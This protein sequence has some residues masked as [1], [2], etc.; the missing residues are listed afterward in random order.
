VGP[1][2][3][4][5]PPAAERREV[6]F[7]DG[8]GYCF[9]VFLAMRLALSVLSMSAT[10]VVHAPGLETDTIPPLSPGWHNIVEGTDRWDAKRFVEIAEFGYQGSAESAAYFPGYPIAIRIVAFVPGIDD[11]GAALLISNIAFL[12]AMVVLYA[13]TTRESSEPI[14]RRTVLFLACFPTSFFFLAPFSE[15]LFLL[16]SLLA[17]WWARSDRWLL[18]GLAG[19]AAAL[20]RNVGVLL[21]PGL[22]IEALDEP[23]SGRR[24]AIVGALLPLAGPIALGLYW[25]KI[26]GDF[27]APFHAQD[28]WHKAFEFPILTLGHAI[29]LGLQGIASAR[30]IYW[31]IDLVVTAAIVV[32]IALRWRVIPPP[33]LAYVVASLLVIFSYPL[34]ARPLVSAPRYALVLFPAYWAMADLWTG[35]AARLVVAAFT[36]VWVAL[37]VIFMNWGYVF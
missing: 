17:F 8:F 2:T 30:G 28:A 22:L 6:R 9:A 11:V 15:S 19:F 3:D 24:T 37:A 32:P 27:L 12:G 7:R 31:T 26:A 16:T 14:A 25:Q 21:V 5:Q 36:V 34:P 10:G 33:Y 4:P 23:R 29:S 13:L 20:V 35:R 1:R 18:A